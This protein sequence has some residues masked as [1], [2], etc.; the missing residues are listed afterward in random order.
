MQ[1]R[2]LIIGSNATVD[3]SLGM[4]YK[5]K[6]NIY[7][8]EDKQIGFTKKLT[9]IKALEYNGF[10]FQRSYSVTSSPQ[11]SK[12][13]FGY[14]PLNATTSDDIVIVAKSVDYLNSKVVDLEFV[15][16]DAYMQIASQSNGLFDFNDNFLVLRSATLEI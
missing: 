16:V 15:D 5:V 13:G 14:T 12:F 8:F 6:Q 1:G 3:T 11:L 4:E 2:L 7:V 9:L 10:S